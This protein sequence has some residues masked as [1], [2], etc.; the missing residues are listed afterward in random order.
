[1]KTSIYN[2][3]FSS[4]KL[5]VIYKSAAFIII[6]LFILSSCVIDPFS[7][8]KYSDSSLKIR[9]SPIYNQKYINIAKENVGVDYID[10][11]DNSEKVNI[12]ARNKQMYKEMN[13]SSQNSDS[14]SNASSNLNLAKKNVQYRALSSSYAHLNE[15]QAPWIKINDSLPNLHDAQDRIDNSNEVD[16]KNF[17]DKIAELKKLLYN[18]KKDL[19]KND[20]N[21]NQ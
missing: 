15:Y 19:S 13:N 7:K 3:R 8:K 6:M 16:I 18:T 9:R 14:S 1:M 4:T 5:F 17:Y 20:N 10:E 11:E 2:S 12:P 21:I